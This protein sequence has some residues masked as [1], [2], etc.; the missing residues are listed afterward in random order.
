MRSVRGWL[1]RVATHC[2]WRSL[3][4]S[5]LV[6]H[7][8]LCLLTVAPSCLFLSEICSAMSRG[9]RPAFLRRAALPSLSRS[10]RARA[11]FSPS[12]RLV[13]LPGCLLLS[14]RLRSHQHQHHPHAHSPTSTSQLQVSLWRRWQH[15]VPWLFRQHA[16]RHHG[17]FI[18]GNMA[19]SSPA[20]TSCVETPRGS[21]SQ[22][23]T[24]RRK[25]HS[26]YRQVAW[27]PL[28]PPTSSDSDSGDG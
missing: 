18:S 13:S 22:H 23:H 25:G 20:A 15:E 6:S 21:A 27:I 26:F 1:H 28:A 12:R 9:R 14:R 10:C 16:L 11:T 2:G 17:L 7:C 19:R 5:S 3:Q 4:P 8:I 24:C